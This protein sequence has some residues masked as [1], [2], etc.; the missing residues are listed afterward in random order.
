M[1][2]SKWF[3]I[4]P[5]AFWFAALLAAGA[6]S[7]EVCN[8]KIVTDASPDYSDLP[9]FLQSSTANLFWKDLP[10]NYMWTDEETL[11]SGTFRLVPDRPV[12]TRFVQYRIANQRFFDCAGLEV[13]DAIRSA[14]FD[15]RL[16][17]PD[18]AG[19]AISLAPADDGSERSGGSDAKEIRSTGGG[20]Q[21]SAISP[22]AASASGLAAKPLGEPVLEPSTLH[23]LGVYW[24]IQGDGN[25]K[26][27]VALDYR[28]AGAA[29]WRRAR[30]LFRVEKGA[31]RLER[32]ESRVKV[33]ADA[34]LF[35]GSVVLLDPATA[36]ELRLKLS[37]PDGATVERRLQARTATEPLAPAGS[38]EYHVVPGAGGGSG[39]RSE[40][41]RG[42]AEAQAQAHAGDIFLLHAGVYEGTFT[43]TRNGEPGRP[44]VWRGAGDGEAVLDG[45][46]SPGRV[47]AAS[48]AHDVW[49][50]EDAQ[51][52]LRRPVIPQHVR[53][54]GRPARVADPRAGPQLGLSEQPLHRHRR[55]LCL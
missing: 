33:P 49:F 11:T 48:G 47:I 3:C 35:A 55:Q 50:G 43:V 52:P 16:A 20:T 4:G 36:Y 28:Q 14:P 21:T 27:A 53:Q 51:Q 41:Y 23:S 54:T 26:A 31:N 46:G 37:E 13:L 5:L 15:L 18:E 45:Q 17:L 38:P 24:I 40:P 39:T 1:D 22:S 12:T 34:W 25:K 2:T 19:P 42:L 44:I 30:P 32:G 6:A 29:A 9:S 8:L 7:G 10:A